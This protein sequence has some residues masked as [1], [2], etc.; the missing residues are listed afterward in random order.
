MLDVLAFGAHP[1]DVEL[2]AGGMMLRFSD[3]GMRCAVVD[4]T[5]GERGSRG[6]AATRA[7]EARVSGELMG[8]AARE[9]LEFPD[10]Q[11][12]PTLE[13]R[14][15]VIEAIRRHRPRIVLAPLPGDLHPDHDAAGQAVRDAF[16]PSGMKNAEADGEPYRPRALFHYFM[17]DERPTDIVVDVTDVWERRLDLARCFSSQLHR[18][19]TGADDFPTLISRPDFLL[20]IEARSRAWGRRAGVEFGEPLFAPQQLAVTDPRAL[21]QALPGEDQVT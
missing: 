9:A 1:D 16:Y 5:R 17:H 2:G 21:L 18:G 10:T 8:L 3:A 15:A 13:L 12:R 11:L 6:T 20:R 4:L 14:R 7:E 19:E